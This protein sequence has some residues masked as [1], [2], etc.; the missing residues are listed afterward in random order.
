[1]V[2][3]TKRTQALVALLENNIYWPD[4]VYSEFYSIGYGV[5]LFYPY[6]T[7]VYPI[8]IFQTFLSSYKHA[9]YLYF[10]L[11][12]LITLLIS[13]HCMKKFSKSTK[14]SILFSML[15]TFS[16]YRSIDFFKRFAL[17]ELVTFTFLPLVFYGIYSILNDK[18][19]KWYY[20]TIGMTLIVYSHLLS[21]ALTSVTIAI[22]LLINYK[23]LTKRKLACLSLATIST[24][25]LSASFLIPFFEQLH[26]NE[27]MSVDLYNLNAE[28][29][30]IIDLFVTG[31]KSLVTFD[32]IAY[33]SIGT[34]M[35][36]F[37]II[38]LFIF[39]KHKS[40]Y[41]QSLLLGLFFYLS[42]SQ[43]FP[44]SLFQQTPLVYLQFPFRLLTMATFF[45]AIP[46]SKLVAD[47]TQNKKQLYLGFLFL[48]F[49]NHGITFYHYK[50]IMTPLKDDDIFQEY[51]SDEQLTMSD[52]YISVR[53]YDYFLRMDYD[54]MES[55]INQEVYINDYTPAFDIL[56]KNHGSYFSAHVS[57]EDD[58]VINLPVLNYKG[59]YVKI[60]GEI[61]DHTSSHRSSVAVSVKGDFVPQEIVVSYRK[62]KAQKISLVI[63]VTTLI[64]FGCFLFKKTFIRSTK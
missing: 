4:I 59:L 29:A 62:T 46:I 12:T 58:V 3:H 18:K 8:A 57:V 1:M 30:P 35:L 38:S 25:L 55:I 2:F 56:V 49:L 23:K 36:V 37:T 51:V 9:C 11:L 43:L 32:S 13:Y 64:I 16:T 42:S 5:N 39:Y 60:N 53:N 48:I 19:S 40:I 28:A 61:V 33:Y 6:L 22:I 34:I 63:S 17:G 54:L 41:R 52:Y 44:W 24:L 14:Q 15:Y 45:F 21:L 50:Y 27:L 31:F 47:Y 26:V 10:Y 20:L 7:T